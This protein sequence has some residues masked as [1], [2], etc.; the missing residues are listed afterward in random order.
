MYRDPDEVE[1]KQS[2]VKIDPTAPA[3]SA[4]RRQRTV[5]YSPTT[6]QPSFQTISSTT[7]RPG[8][9]SGRTRVPFDRRSLLEDIRRRE[10][11]PNNPSQYTPG[12]VTDLEAALHGNSYVRAADVAHN[13][14][15]QR[16]RLENGRAL[17]RD[18]L[19][20]ERP[21][22]RMRVA[23]DTTV[24]EAPELR[25]PRRTSPNS[26]E[27]EEGPANATASQ[28]GH[29]PRQP[30]TSEESSEN[31][32]VRR[33]TP[34]LGAA[35]L[36]PRFAPAHRLNEEAEG[37][38]I[39]AGQ[40]LS[41]R[42]D[43][44]AILAERIPSPAEA[45]NDEDRAFLTTL[46]SELE[47][48]RRRSPETL[49]IPYLTEEA[50]Y[51][52]SVEIRLNLLSAS[53]TGETRFNLADSLPPLRRTGPEDDD[54]TRRAAVQ[55]QYNR[56]QG[57]RARQDA[58]DGL[59]DRQRSYSPDD[60]TWE[61]M[62]TTIPPDERVPSAN[63]S[64]TTASASAN[65]RSSNSATSSYGT[66]VTVPSIYT[67]VEACPAESSDSD[68]DDM[69]DVIEEWSIDGAETRSRETGR[70]GASG[71]QPR[72]VHP[73]HMEAHLSRLQE[74]SQRRPWLGHQSRVDGYQTHPEE[75]SRRPPWLG[76]QS[77]LEELSR[78]VTQHRA[79]DE[80]HGPR[81][82]EIAR[83]EE[84]RRLESSI[85][86]LDRQLAE[87]RAGGRQRPEERL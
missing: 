64:F 55:Q 24:V 74:L 70:L 11:A 6:R 5:R 10:G 76:H 60:D 3:R 48:M 40:S 14:A 37:E 87:E 52:R 78:R 71:S 35:S 80:F 22:E 58:L 39:A 41:T 68:E 79:H 8:S 26:G 57:L 30:Y 72:F 83:E 32:P 69:F 49:T 36:T 20:Y 86:R 27:L 84:L 65:S 4:I 77:R 45:L 67:D 19:S 47:A 17:L 2:A 59:G 54:E 33:P 46:A 42:Q 50:A 18:A 1:T 25:R 63:S 85:Q 23:R 31:S 51:L 28:R 44:L 43:S 15:S 34:P 12:E 66:L 62:L 21:R 82:R 53:G 7:Y 61:T 81:A 75:S 13:Q 16:T 73:S 56:S 38:S 29:W 9:T